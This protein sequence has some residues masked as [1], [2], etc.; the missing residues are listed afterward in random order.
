[1]HACKHLHINH[2]I[3]IFAKKKQDTKIFKGSP[4]VPGIFIQHRIQS[5]FV[6]FLWNIIS[7]LEVHKTLCS[8][9]T[10]QNYCRKCM[11]T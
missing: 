7:N 10:T 8:T 4:L 6:N 1:M 11:F 2:P 9:L 5:F 3:V